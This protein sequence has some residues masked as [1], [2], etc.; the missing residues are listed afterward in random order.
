MPTYVY[1]SLRDPDLTY[2]FSQSM[3]DEPYREHPETGEPLRRILAAPAI[4]RRGLKRS[5]RVDKRSPAATA[6]ACASSTVLD[7]LGVAGQTPRYRPASG[8]G[9][10]GHGHGHGKHCNGHHEQ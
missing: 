8:G 10:R 2:E 5:A 9:H 7:A 1:R 4:H 3:N 6:C